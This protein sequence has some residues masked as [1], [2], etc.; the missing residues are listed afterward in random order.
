M[1]F[2]TISMAAHFRT[3]GARALAGVEV[4]AAATLT[5][6]GFRGPRNLGVTAGNRIPGNVVPS[7]GATGG[8]FGDR[9]HAVPRR[10]LR[11]TA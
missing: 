10:V 3:A 1:R 11:K 2:C 4:E 8:S 5:I 6:A 7:D 9:L